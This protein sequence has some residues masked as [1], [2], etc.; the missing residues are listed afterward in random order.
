MPAGRVLAPWEP[1]SYN[2]CWPVVW[3][4]IRGSACS[5]RVWGVLVSSRIGV[6]WL[7]VLLLAAPACGLETDDAAVGSETL[8]LSASP[9]RNYIVVLRDDAG[10]P[11]RH[12]ARHGLLPRRIYRSA[13]LGFAVRLNPVQLR[14]V[15]ADPYVRFVEPDRPMY[16][17]VPLYEGQERI[18]L[19]LSAVAR[20]GSGTDIDV[21]IAIIDSGID[22]DHPS[23]NAQG[24]SA[25]PDPTYRRCVNYADTTGVNSKCD[26]KN[27][28]GT[29]VAGIAAARRTEMVGGRSIAG[30][31]PGARLWAVRVLDETGSGWDSDVVAGVDYVTSFAGEIEVAN[32]SLGGVGA[33]Q[34]HETCDQ[35]VDDALHLAICNSVEAGVTYVVAAGNEMQDTQVHVPGAYDE[36]ITVSA[37]ADFDGLPGQLGSD[38]VAFEHCTEN[39]DDSFACFSNYGADVD[40]MAP[41]V[42][43]ASTYMGG[44]YVYM[45]GTSMSSPFVAGAAALYLS[46][47][48]GTSPEGVK[49]VLRA[50]GDFA[51]C[52]ALPG[53]RCTDDGPGDTVQEPLLYLGVVEQPFAYP[54]ASAPP[55]APPEMNWLLSGS[56]YAQIAGAAGPDGSNALRLGREDDVTGQ[57][58]YAIGTVCFYDTT[59]AYLEASFSVR[60]PA[61]ASWDA[62]GISGGGEWLQWWWVNGA[63]DVFDDA[64][65]GSFG[66]GWTDVRVVID[67]AVTAT[68]TFQIVG[69]GSSTLPLTAWPSSTTTPLDCLVLFASGATEPHSFDIDNVTLRAR[70]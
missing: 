69:G 7:M 25:P 37:L 13:L 52:G 56:G 45:S 55:A 32:L 31:A 24:P 50:T 47:H 4:T 17:D 19:P 26:D 8:S 2:P 11:A 41:G 3:G 5:G 23:L 14:R 40:L 62:L 70:P 49:N 18:D 46:R 44:G 51:P 29:H 9:V 36:V 63:G 20:V 66:T 57:A 43:I 64:V 67:R 10:E 16:A 38:S 39:V 22:Y 58:D 12:A 42:R 35:I 33:D 59:S 6:R 54:A 48:P 53:G 27:G 68:A 61:F 65:F 30:V 1:E 21:D 28:H 15:Q 60:F 34:P